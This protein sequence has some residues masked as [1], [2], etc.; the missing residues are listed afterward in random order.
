[1]PG[2]FPDDFTALELFSDWALPTEY[3]RNSYRWRA[4]L[5]ESQA[6]YDAMLGHGAAALEYL[7]GFPI[8]ELDARQ[9]SLLNLCLAFTEVSVTIEMYGEPQPKYVFPI[10]RFVPL[11]DGWNET[12]A[13]GASA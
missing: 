11:H 9:T 10:A 13:T 4:T 12:F 1:M 7:N 2:T 5:A 8:D 6:F 3:G